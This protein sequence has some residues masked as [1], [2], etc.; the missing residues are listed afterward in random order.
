MLSQLWTRFRSLILFCMSGG[1]AL[2]IDI[3]V[4]YLC[5][6][7]AGFY[8]GRLCSF[9]AAATFTWLFNRHITFQAERSGSILKEYAA[10]L[11]SMAVGGA[12]NYAAYAASVGSFELVRQ[13]PAWGV[14]IGSLI[15]LTFN[16]LSAKRIMQG[17]R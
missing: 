3:G 1:L 13:Q 14:A 16:Y 12:I 8:G 15:G 7:W 2:F 6:P 4:L 5:K 9:L 17:T 11:S 10:Y